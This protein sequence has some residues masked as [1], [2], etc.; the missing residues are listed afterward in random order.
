[1]D[2]SLII[3]TNNYENI[4]NDLIKKVLINLTSV[5]C[6]FS[7]VKVV[8]RN[9]TT[10][11]LAQMF[12][13]NTFILSYFDDIQILNLIR[14]AVNIN[15][16]VQFQKEEFGYIVQQ[17]ERKCFILDILKTDVDLSIDTLKKYF[18]INNMITL[19]LFGIENVELSKFVNNITNGQINCN[20]Y[21][22]NGDVYFC[23]K[24]HDSS[25]LNQFKQLFYYNFAHN[26]YSDDNRQLYQIVNELLLIRNKRLAIY[27]NCNECFNFQ[28]KKMENTINQIF[29]T[30][31]SY[32]DLNKVNKLLKK[33][34]LDM[35]INLYEE[36][37]ETRIHIY[38]KEF[39]KQYNFDNK[40]RLYTKEYIANFL[41]F[42]L[43]QILYK[44]DNNI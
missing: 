33:Y 13:K 26:I 2:S 14:N 42:K 30:K 8:D 36:N 43:F 27:N 6:S 12:S 41:L 21:I 1:M 37:D 39:D 23:C 28:I 38:T 25:I 9:I 5:N 32:N 29:E 24:T 18:D 19:K 17:N 20:Y 10:Q 7:C 31:N 4:N 35:Y 11:D 34:D 15:Y 44:N 3:V 16:S 22:D 40:N